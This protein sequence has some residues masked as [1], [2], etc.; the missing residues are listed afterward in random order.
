MY[1]VLIYILY[2][3]SIYSMVKFIVVTGSLLSGLGKGITSSSIGLL[4]QARGL[5]VTSIKIDPYLNI[6]SGTLSPY[7]HGECFTLS[8]SCDCLNLSKI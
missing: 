4:L 1:I 7:E 6:D 3:I 8:D 2:Q 5:T